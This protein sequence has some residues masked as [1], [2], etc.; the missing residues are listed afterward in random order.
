M[1]DKVLT[2]N[3]DRKKGS[4]RRM[5]EA[6]DHPFVE[7]ALKKPDK[8]ANRVAIPVPKVTEEEL[9][10]R[11][12][13]EEEAMLLK[14]AEEAKKKHNRLALEEYEKMVLVSNTN[15]DDSIIEARNVEEALAKITVT[16]SLPMDRH[17][18]KESDSS[19]RKRV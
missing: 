19:G 10:R 12:E 1:R 6:R 7:K 13:E 5:F 14:R 17:P 8:K 3:E 4:E 18:E 16:D 15:R 11:R 2:S 9:R